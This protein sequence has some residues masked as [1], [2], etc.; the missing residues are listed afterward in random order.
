MNEEQILDYK[1]YNSVMDRMSVR[2][3]IVLSS[4]Y[5]IECG[6]KTEDVREL[7]EVKEVR[8]IV[9]EKLLVEELSND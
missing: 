7:A 4:K 6:I 1:I 9:L 3:Y 8:E 5:N 2:E